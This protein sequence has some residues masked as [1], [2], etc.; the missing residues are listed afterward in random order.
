MDHVEQENLTA[1]ARALCREHLPAGV[2]PVIRWGTATRAMGLARMGMMLYRSP[3]ITFSR[4]LF[5]ATTAEDRV[6]TVYH[7]VAHL[8]V[9]YQIQGHAPLG[10][11]M[12]T[13]RA[14]G[15]H[16]RRW[17]AVM[18][19]FGYHDPA[20]K[21]SVRLPRKP[22]RDD[23]A[24]VCSCPSA[25]HTMSLGRMGRASA[26]RCR[27]CRQKLLPLDT[28]TALA[29]DMLRSAHGQ[30][31]GLPAA[32][33][34]RVSMVRDWPS[35]SVLRFAREILPVLPEVVVERLAVAPPK[36]GTP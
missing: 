33:V 18:A 5:A 30:L 14:E 19:G 10:A 15:P 35:A 3:R 22:R 1:L 4:P 17:R 23:V 34:S 25:Q 36:P 8:V 27:T 21:H 12:T 2:E 11:L 31:H 24:L 9:F 7:E 26:Y 13:L 6:E 20:V 32:I 29:I 28:V 16:G